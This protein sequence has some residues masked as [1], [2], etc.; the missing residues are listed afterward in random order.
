M[1]AALIISGIVLIGL[2]ILLAHVCRVCNEIEA[3]FRSWHRR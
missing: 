2:S 1:I 3:M